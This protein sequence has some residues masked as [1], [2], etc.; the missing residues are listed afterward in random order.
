[1]E[2]D[3]NYFTLDETSALI[4]IANSM[5]LPHFWEVVNSDPDSLVYCSLCFDNNFQKLLL[6][7][8]LKHLKLKAFI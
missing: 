7:H 1:M 4:E 6:L 8:M 3:R 2:T 5:N